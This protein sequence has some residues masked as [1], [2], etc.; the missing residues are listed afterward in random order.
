MMN[1]QTSLKLINFALW[2]AQILLAASLVWSFFMKLF[3][4]IEQLSLMWPWAGQVSPV[5]ITLTGIVDLCAAVGL[6]FPSVLRIRP[7]FTPIAAVGIILLMVCASIFHILR[8]E[9]SVI[10]FNVIFAFI[11]AFI[12]WGRF[13][14]IPIPTK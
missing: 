8:G 2:I 3:Q 10:G 14:K 1:Q 13:K 6:I 5:L 11:A 9:T 7:R 4:P 12:A